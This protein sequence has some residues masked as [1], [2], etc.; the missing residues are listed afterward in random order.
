[1]AQVK[2]D[3]KRSSHPWPVEVPENP[4][5]GDFAEIMANLRAGAEPL[6]ATPCE[7]AYFRPSCSA[8]GV[9]L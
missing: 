2:K 4:A 8:A 7:T 5:G 6:W 9:W 1:M 3:V